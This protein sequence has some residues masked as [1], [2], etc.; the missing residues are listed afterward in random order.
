METSTAL[1]QDTVLTSM[2]LWWLDYS[3]IPSGWQLIDPSWLQIC[4]C[5][6]LSGCPCKVYTPCA[7][8]PQTAGSQYS[9]T[10]GHSGPVPTSSVISYRWSPGIPGTHRHSR[11]YHGY[12]Y[13]SN[14]RA[15]YSTWSRTGCRCQTGIRTGVTHIHWVGLVC[16]QAGVLVCNHRCIHSDTVH[17]VLQISPEQRWGICQ[18]YGSHCEWFLKSSASPVF[19]VPYYMTHS[20]EIHR[21]IVSQREKPGYNCYDA[22]WQHRC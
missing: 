9:H 1:S 3:R 12:R 17:L 7:W 13:H 18:C 11:V 14:G 2:F 15:G 16:N 19:Q 6:S 10:L 22:W 5:R 21:K 8:Q 4:I 20:S